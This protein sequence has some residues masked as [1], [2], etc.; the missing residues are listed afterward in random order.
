TLLLGEAGTG[1]TTMLRTAIARRLERHASTTRCVHLSNPALTRGEF[2]E[3]LAGSFGLSAEAAGSKTRL[4][5]ELELTLREHRRHG[6]I[7]AL[8]VDE[9]QSLP[10][11]LLEEIRL[12]ANIESDTEKML[13]IILAGQP[14]LATRL[15]Q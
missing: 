8:V 9:S 14:E 5:R 7:S 6:V 11:H 13:T 4:L 2:L 10:D 3:F 1:K 12:L 15:N